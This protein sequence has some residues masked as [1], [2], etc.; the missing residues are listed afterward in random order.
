MRLARSFVVLGAAIGIAL[1]PSPAGASI[2]TFGPR[3]TVQFYGTSWDDYSDAACPDPAALTLADVDAATYVNGVLVSCTAVTK[4]GA[5]VG[6]SGSPVRIGGW[7]YGGGTEHVLSCPTGAV[8]TGAQGRLGSWLDQIQ[9]QCAPLQP[10]GTL[11]APSL[12]AAA[13]GAGGAP[14]SAFCPAGQMAVGARI[15]FD[16]FDGYIAGIGLQ[17]AGIV[18]AAV[19]P[20]HGPPG[21]GVQITGANFAAGEKVRVRYKTGL[22]SPKTVTLCNA[23]V[24]TDGTFSCLGTIP[25]TNAGATGRHSITAKGMSSSL[26]AATTFRLE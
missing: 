13:G 12:T 18:R 26:Q 5:K 16:D 25:T 21:T 8:V 15:F 17:C 22:A 11:G 3:T 19:S 1:G 10:D 9:F 20:R 2:A 6:L 24:V 23:T 14:V 4:S 7:D